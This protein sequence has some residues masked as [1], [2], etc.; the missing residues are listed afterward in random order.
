MRMFDIKPEFVGANNAS[1][2]LWQFAAESICCLLNISISC[3]SLH[4]FNFSPLCLFKCFLNLPQ[5]AF[6]TLDA[7]SI[8]CDSSSHSNQLGFHCAFQMSSSNQNTGSSLSELKSQNNHSSQLSNVSIVL[9]YD[10]VIKFKSKLS[11]RRKN[12]NLECLGIGWRRQTIRVAVLLSVWSAYIHILILNIILKNN[13]STVIFCPDQSVG[14]SLTFRGTVFE[15]SH[16]I[17]SHKCADPVCDTQLLRVDDL[18][19]SIVV[20]LI[21]LIKTSFTVFPNYFIGHWNVSQR[22]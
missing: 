6:W 14:K 2:L 22:T 3:H 15:A 9:G 20:L 4:L 10:M 18:S 8:C 16:L 19:L 12:S 5:K 7:A 13:I 21:C 1:L 11:D 17:K